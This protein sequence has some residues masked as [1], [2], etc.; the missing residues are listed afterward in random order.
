MGAT[1]CCYDNTRA[2]SFFATLMKELVQR[3][4]YRDLPALRVDISIYINLLYNSRRRTRRSA[5]SAQL[6]SK[7]L[8]NTNPM[9]AA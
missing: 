2:E 8:I 6:P 5:T 1:G 9:L 3:N 4:A 7:Q